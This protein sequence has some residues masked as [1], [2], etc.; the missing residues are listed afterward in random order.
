MI[1][2]VKKNAQ[3]KKDTLGPNWTHWVGKAVEKLVSFAM[4]LNISNHI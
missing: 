4:L 2:T 1:S 3:A